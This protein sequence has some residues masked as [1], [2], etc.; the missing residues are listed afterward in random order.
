MARLKIL[1]KLLDEEA[2]YASEADLKRYLGVQR[3]AYDAI[4]FPAVDFETF[5]AFKLTCTPRQAEA[6]LRWAKEGPP[7]TRGKRAPLTAQDRADIAQR[8]GRKR[9]TGESKS[10]VETSIETPPT[11]T[12]PVQAPDD[13]APLP[14]SG[15][16]RKYARRTMR[17]IDTQLL[18]GELT[19]LQEAVLL[20]Q[21]QPLMDILYPPTKQGKAPRKRGGKGGTAARKAPVA[22]ATPEPADTAPVAPDTPRRLFSAPADPIVAGYVPEDLNALQTIAAHYHGEKG[23]FSYAAFRWVNRTLFAD[24][25]PTTLIQ[26][27]LTAYGRCLG[28]TQ[29]EAERYPVITLHPGIWGPGP[30]RWHPG[31]RMTL[32]TVIHE[33]LHAY[34][35]YVIGQEKGHSSHDN[36]TWASECMRVGPL[37]A[38]PAFK[39]A[40]TKRMWKADTETGENKY[41]RATP[42]GCIDMDAL[43][44]FPQSLRP[45]GYFQGT[46][47]PWD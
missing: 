20:A 7:M 30:D 29:P 32:D 41:T 17:E 28:Y 25:I 24:Q 9:P 27:A 8:R 1:T 44:Y 43:A 21:R 6:L 31:P 38:L 14:D 40:P 12:P 18:Q 35:L 23:D 15:V 39:A 36:P 22:S 4:E 37:L 5:L 11:P 46:A 2:H 26:W 19:D 33:C 42:A 13:T 10:L 47:L 16:A 45:N 3:Q 34:I